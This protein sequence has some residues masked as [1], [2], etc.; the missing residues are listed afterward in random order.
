MHSSDLNL[1]AA[2]DALLQEG[3]VVG[4]ANRAGITPPAMSRALARLREVTGDPL[5]VRAGR[6]LTPTPRASALRE[7]V[8][9]T[10]LEV[11]ALLGPEPATSPRT[12]QRR[13]TIRADDAVTA[14]L[15]PLLLERMRR[16]APG[17]TVV[18]TAEG[19][20]DVSAL[21]DG[22]VDLDIGVQGK[23]GPEIRT[24]KL[25]DD[26]RVVLLRRT[27]RRRRAAMSL[28]DLAGRAHID[29]SRRG[30][31]RGPIDAALAQA[32]L[33]RSVAVVVPNQL[34]AAILV[35]Q[36]DAVS[37]VSRRFAAS[38]TRVLELAWAP[39]P[40]GLGTVAVAMA[41]HPR[42]DADVG[43]AWFRGE[44]VRLSARVE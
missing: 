36:T 8:H 41:W 18:F 6:G 24:R 28:R 1:L 25:F 15:G 37:L 43:H 12:L 7:R 4:A 16:D 17:V 2:L 11:Q 3:S 33:S 39:A 29:V 14:V 9:A 34:A 5:L 22:G 32:G 19:D 44:I 23:L 13:F 30:R 20:E 40:T 42:F 35:A 26:E 10:L 38:I 27:G 31:S 21:R